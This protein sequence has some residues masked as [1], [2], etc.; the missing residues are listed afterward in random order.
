MRRALAKLEMEQRVMTRPRTVSLWTRRWPRAW[1]FSPRRGA[2]GH[3]LSPPRSPAVL[4]QGQARSRTEKANYN[5]DIRHT[6]SRWIRSPAPLHRWKSRGDSSRHFGASRFQ[7]RRDPLMVKGVIYT[8]AAHADRHRARAKTRVIWSHSL[9]EGKRGP[10]P[11]GS[12][13]AGGFVWTDARA[14]SGYLCD[15]GIASLSST[16][17]P[18]R[19]PS[20]ATGIVD[21]NPERCRGEPADRPRPGESASFHAAWQGTW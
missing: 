17:A 6:Y 9:R 2:V 20:S 4:A 8:T 16:P 3:V 13:P 5:S 19:R 1:L 12:C 7:A 21:L 18:A 14:T 11:R 15:N 10:S